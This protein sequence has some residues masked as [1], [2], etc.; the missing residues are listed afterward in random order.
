MNETTEWKQDSGM[1]TP[2]SDE[3]YFKAAT[4]AAGVVRHEQEDYDSEHGYQKYLS[5]NRRSSSR[6]SGFQ[7][8]GGR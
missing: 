7:V 6:D 5:A 4:G 3:G 1:R 2:G 8:R